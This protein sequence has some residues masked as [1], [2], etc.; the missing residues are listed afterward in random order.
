MVKII[1]EVVIKVKKANS[2]N[3]NS[4]TLLQKVIMSTN[5]IRLRIHGCKLTRPI[6]PAI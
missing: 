2:N 4:C 6:L 3:N 1:G 5:K